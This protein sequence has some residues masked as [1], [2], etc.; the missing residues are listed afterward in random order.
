M[1]YSKFNLTLLS[2]LTLLVL[3]STGQVGAVDKKPIAGVWQ[4]LQVQ[5]TSGI[6]GKRFDLYRNNREPYLLESGYLIDG[7]E[8]RP[9]VHPWQGEHIGKY[10]HTVVLDYLITK[11][12]KTKKELDGLVK[13]LLATQLEDGYLGTYPPNITFMKCPENGVNN[14][15]VAD[16]VGADVEAQI[17]K[18]GKKPGGGWDVWTFRYNLHGL[19]FYNKYFPS[20]DVVTACKKM[21]DLLIRVYGPGQ[22]NLTKYGT[23]KGISAA[24]LLE[25]IVM[26]YE[27][28]GEKKYLD[29]AE[30]IV[31]CIEEN[32]DLDMTNSIMNNED[33]VHPGEGK[34]YQLMSTFLGYYRLYL[35]THNDKYLNVVV[36]SWEIIEEKHLNV[37]GGP[38]SRKMD[39]NG[40]QEC[41]AK[42]DAFY[43]GKMNVEGCCSMSW[44]QMCSD[45]YELTGDPKYIKEA[46]YNFYNESM[47]HQGID[48][49]KYTYYTRMNR[50]KGDFTEY[51]HCCSSSIPRGMYVYAHTM[52]GHIGSH[53][54][55]G[56]LSPYSASLTDQFGG[57]TVNIESAF[58]YEGKVTITLSPAQSN[59]FPVELVIPKNTSFKNVM[60]NGQRA[61][62]AKNE[63]G[64]YEIKGTWE[65]GDTI[66]VETQ[67]QL[68]AHTQRGED[69]LAWVAFTYGPITLAQKTLD[70]KTDEPFMNFKEE[71]KTKMVNLLVKSPGS[72]IAFTV[73]GT[74]LTFIPVWE[75]A[76]ELQF[77]GT[78]TYFGIEGN[79]N[80]PPVDTKKTKKKGSAK[81]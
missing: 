49:V 71:E 46:E 61:Q 9:G 39:Y 74:D 57:G 50:T 36:K 67:Y 26:L 73:K 44:I 29:F 28:T 14:K 79:P 63:R 34:A 4:P 70:L 23:R 80:V 7:F 55:I 13:R 41:F 69:N 53:L 20:E 60:V 3:F 33:V 54:I 30:H 81:K 45:L 22:Y 38:W 56:S 1:K 68:K 58:P 18:G 8:H 11:D 77:G 10:I 59:S 62:G 32:P 27:Q 37:A 48:G 64:N 78:K 19:L 25:S 24:V 2:I 35:V 6:M 75:T 21:G 52:I 40:N 16:D 47:V 15:D 43:P 66:T 12:P 65:K 5:S 17:S 31:R 72:K 76:N 51:I 42:N